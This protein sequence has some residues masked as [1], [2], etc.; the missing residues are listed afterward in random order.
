MRQCKGAEK[1]AKM[2]PG[3]KRSVLAPSKRN[4]PSISHISS[5]ENGGL[6]QVPVTSDEPAASS[7]PRFTR[8][9]KP[10]RARVLGI[11]LNQV[12]KP[13]WQSGLRPCVSRC[14]LQW[15]SRWV[16]AAFSYGWASGLFVLR[17]VHGPSLGKRAASTHRPRIPNKRPGTLTVSGLESTG[18]SSE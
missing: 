8:I 12:F 11:A 15:S 7:V 18:L 1:W 14:S 13:S 3:N 10:F 16:G 5:G 2:T 6:D 4:Q 17:T 9:G